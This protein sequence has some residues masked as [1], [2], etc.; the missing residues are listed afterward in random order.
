MSLRVPD[1]TCL[2]ATAAA[3]KGADTAIY[4][5][6]L[7]AYLDSHGIEHFS[8]R[9]VCPVGRRGLLPAPVSRWPHIVPTLRVWEWVRARFGGRPV[10]VN[11]GWRDPEYNRRVG[12]APDSLHVAFNATDAHVKGIAPL[13]VAREVH[14]DHPE[15]DLLGIGGYRGF[16]HIDT[17][18]LLGREAPARWKGAN[19]EVW[20]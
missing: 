14:R 6:A 16:V 1:P 9:E 8:A 4:L 20:W 13:A 7:D 5:A 11:S 17:R 18:G 19:V 10:L 12:G 3:L 2:A 15:A